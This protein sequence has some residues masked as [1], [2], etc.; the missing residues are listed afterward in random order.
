[1]GQG[2][3]RDW[4]REWASLTRHIS[5]YVPKNSEIKTFQ[6]PLETENTWL[7]YKSQSLKHL[8]SKP[9]QPSILATC[10]LTLR[11]KQMYSTSQEK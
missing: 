7:K 3:Q 10:C 6:V 1:M 11:L 4:S 2:Q 9:L 5:I 8:S